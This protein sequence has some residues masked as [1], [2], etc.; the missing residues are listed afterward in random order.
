MVVVETLEQ[1]NLYYKILEKLPL[2]KALVM[3][4]QEAISED[5]QKDSRIHSFKNFLELGKD[6][7][8]NVMDQ[9]MQKQKPG[10]CAC[11]IYTS[12]TTGNPKGVMLSHDNLV[13][14]STSMII[15]IIRSAPVDMKLEPSE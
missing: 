11:L 2:I 1:L 8:N 7:N 15:D 14:N 4:G 9:I 6:I 13:F 10:T 3:W 12:G 5:F